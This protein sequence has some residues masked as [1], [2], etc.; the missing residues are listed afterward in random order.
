M[1]ATPRKRSKLILFLFIL[2]LL[3]AA[4]SAVYSFLN[5]GPWIIPEDAKRVANPLKPSQFEPLRARQLYMDKCAECH[6]DT[7]KG[8]G[9]QAKM[10]S[11]RPTNFTDVPSMTAETDGAIFYKIS[12][13]HR[14]MPG[15]KKRYS[16]E[17]RWQLVLLIR[18]FA[19]PPPPA[20]G[21]E[22]QPSAK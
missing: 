3:V 8:D 4:G 15:F 7:G 22:T 18:A 13:G 9:S 1:P 11:P 19:A 16:E 6:G 17:Q 21:V 14:P 20:P 10:Y 2:L 12:E 5:P